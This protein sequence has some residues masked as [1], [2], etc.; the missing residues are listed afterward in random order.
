MRAEEGTRYFQEAA[1]VVTGAASGIGRALARALAGEGCH[2]VLADLQEDALEELQKELEAQEVR[3]RCRRA[4]VRDAEDVEAVVG[5]AIASFGRLDFVF[6]NAGI[7]IQGEAQEH[8][9]D[10]WRRIVDVNLFGVV[11]GVHAAYPHMLRQGFGHVVNTASF[12]GLVPTPMLAGYTATKHAVV[13]LTR[14]LRAEGADRGVRATA[15]CPGRVRT[16]IL[17]GGRYGR[18]IPPIREDVRR[19]Q[20]ERG[21]MMDPD[22]LARRVLA[23]LRRNRALIVEP[24][25]VR[26]IEAFG[27]HFPRTLDR[28]AVRTFARMQRETREA[29]EA[30]LA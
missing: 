24:R 29:V 4:D 19:R 15:V 2:L 20:A 17:S 28:I 21:P 8:G 16:P 5:E 3:V 14:V 23:G 1:A 27:R 10:D 25:A 6:N 18:V 22:L 12:A 11:N 30:S 26:W 9:L 13:G 7:V